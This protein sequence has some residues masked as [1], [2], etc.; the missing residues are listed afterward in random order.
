MAFIR[1]VKCSGPAGALCNGLLQYRA[2]IALGRYEGVYYS[3]MI[4]DNIYDFVK[5]FANFNAQIDTYYLLVYISFP[6]AKDSGWGE[7]FLGRSIIDA[8]TRTF[9]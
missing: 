3:M 4:G 8:I 2:K 9:L 7:R 6:S 1:L 5:G